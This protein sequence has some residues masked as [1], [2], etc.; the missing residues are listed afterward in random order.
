MD[1]YNAWCEDYLSKFA[2]ADPNCR[3]PK[4]KGKYLINELIPRMSKEDPEL[5]AELIAND[6]FTRFTD[7][8]LGMMKFGACTAHWIEAKTDRQ[9]SHV[10][11]PMHVGSAPFWG[12]SVER[13]KR[14]TTRDQMNNILPYFSVQVLV[15]SDDM[16]VSNGS[17]EVVPCS[18]QIKDIDALIHDKE[19][20]AKFEPQFKNVTLKSGDFLIFNR[21]LVHRG[22]KNLSDARRNA[23]ISQCVYLWGVQQEIIDGKGV[24]E[25]LSQTEKYKQMT[26]HEKEVFRLRICPPFPT[27]TKLST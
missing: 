4:Q 15:A 26:E 13:L 5:C 8:L 11:Y 14:F 23:L 22:G 6:H 20:Y 2:D 19:V 3:H 17:T 9:L 21:G 7:I 24:L 10:D 1:K 12:G 16:D 25:K 18:Q 27:D